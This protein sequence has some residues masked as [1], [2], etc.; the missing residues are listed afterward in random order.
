MEWENNRKVKVGRTEKCEEG[1]EIQKESK[2]HGVRFPFPEC[3]FMIQD[4]SQAFRCKKVQAES[5]RY[6]VEGLIG[7]HKECS[8]SRGVW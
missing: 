3:F 1:L 4:K 7:P 8:L 2:T 5:I 6:H